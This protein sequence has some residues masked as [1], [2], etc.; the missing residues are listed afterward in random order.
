MADSRSLVV[1]TLDERRYALRLQAVERV[2]RVADIEPL[3][4]AP[5]IVLGV[6]N[7]QGRIIPVVDVRTRFRLPRR[8]IAL[9]DHLIV[10]HTTTRA[11]ALL[12][13]A[14]LGVVACAEE[15]IT[16]AGAILPGTAQVEGVVKRE[17]GLIVIHDLDTFLSWEEAQ[18][19]EDALASGGGK[20]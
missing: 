10:A 13:D 1:F 5:A 15:E 4:Q 20:Q 12:A 14:V 7:V 8:E 9:S 17:D 11:V 18:A 6:I 16:A 2:V 19:L 3:P